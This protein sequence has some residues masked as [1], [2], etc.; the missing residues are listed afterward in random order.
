METGVDLMVRKR[1]DETGMVAQEW[2]KALDKY[3]SEPFLLDRDQ[4]IAPERIT[5]EDEPRE[6]DDRDA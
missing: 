1:K 2:F 3:A 6:E 5:F 4:P